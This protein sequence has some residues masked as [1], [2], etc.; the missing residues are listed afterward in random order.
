MLHVCQTNGF[1]QLVRQPTRDDHLLDLVI[2]DIA[3]TS[4]AVWAKISDHNMVLAKFD[5]GIP[6][7]VV[8][9][10]SVFEYSKASWRDVKRDIS[11]FEWTPMDIMTVDDAERF[12]HH[13]VFEILEGHIPR[14][15]IRE[16][17]STHP[18]V[19]DRCVEAIRLKNDSVGTADSVS[20]SVRCSKVIFEEFLSYTERMR[21]KLLKERRGSK[22]WWK[23]ANE[24]MG[25]SSSATSIPALRSDGA[26]V[27]EAAAKADVFA[28]SF[29]AKF[30]L[31]DA[32]LNEFSFDWPRVVT[33]DFVLIRRRHVQRA[34]A[35]VDV[36]SGTGPD[37]LSARVLNICSKELSL[38]LSKLARQMVAQ[39][40]WPTAWTMHWL[41]PLHKRKA[42]SDPLNYR[43]INLT[44]QVSKVV[45]RL[46]SS[47][48]TPLLEARA[49][50]ATQF[51][52][53]KL[54]GARDAV[55]F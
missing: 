2:S 23:I 22:G 19:N 20:L 41:V 21:N 13:K 38:P 48:F 24:I 54:H 53:R 9:T 4:V 46:L 14:R 33:R 16:R 42:V 51:A 55:L 28:D 25:K 8:I 52:Y 49:F 39:G 18:W 3:A 47:H 40:I 7:S 29:A 1:K 31:P 44:A 35:K 45:E 50:G 10:R 6:E 32:E 34:L 26:W 27:F 5:I 37:N 12:F 15:E 36:D 17:K 11:A 43:A 30:T